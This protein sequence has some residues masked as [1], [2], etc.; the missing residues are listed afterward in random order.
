MLGL[1]RLLRCNQW[2]GARVDRLGLEVGFAVRVCGGDVADGVA[3][4]V[5]EERAVW[6]MVGALD[7]SA[8]PL[9]ELDPHAAEVVVHRLSSV[10]ELVAAEKVIPCA[11]YLRSTLAFVNPSQ[12]WQ[13]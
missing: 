12:N 7:A 6:P 8:V 5:V 2:Q 3:V 11:V 10:P 1:L 9:V 13:G 4:G